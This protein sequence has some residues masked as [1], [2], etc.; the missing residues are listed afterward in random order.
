MK[1]L[2]TP[3]FVC[4]ALFLLTNILSYFWRSDGYGIY[5]VDDGFKAVGF[6]FLCYV[7]GGM[8]WRRDVY[9]PAIFQNAALAVGASVFGAWLY[10]KLRA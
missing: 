3:F 10:S 7:E 9:A 4:L 5:K 6:P 8:S 1:R 2:L